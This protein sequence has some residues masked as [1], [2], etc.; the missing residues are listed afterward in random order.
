MEVAD[1]A[2]HLPFPFGDA[3]VPPPV[4]VDIGGGFGGGPHTPVTPAANGGTSN[5]AADTLPADDADVEARLRLLARAVFAVDFDDAKTKATVFIPRALIHNALLQLVPL[6]TGGAAPA[7]S[8]TGGGPLRS[9]P[10]QP[11]PPSA[12]RLA[13][14]LA[15]KRIGYWARAVFGLRSPKTARLETRRDV[16]VSFKGQPPA[17]REPDV[18]SFLATSAAGH[19]TEDG[20]RIFSLRFFRL[21][22]AADFRAPDCCLTAAE[23]AA[24]RGVLA[25]PTVAAV[26]GV[27]LRTDEPGG[28]VTGLRI[29]PALVLSP[30]PQL[31]RALS[32]PQHGLRVGGKRPRGRGVSTEGGAAGP[33]LLAGDATSPSAGDEAAVTPGAAAAAASAAMV[34]AVAA[35]AAAA[36]PGGAASEPEGLAWLGGE[37]LAGEEGGGGAAAAAVGWTRVVGV[38]L[39]MWLDVGAAEAA[40]GGGGV[41]LSVPVKEL[42]KEQSTGVRTL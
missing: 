13:A 31:G 39:G 18:R 40:P 1:P 7:P 27:G 4:T 12:S 37:C 11:P 2:G 38:D 24:L 5:G 22:L 34:A 35:A 32:Y 42:R 15:T 9:S 29:P 21:R 10:P 3:A 6:V 14:A 20:R 33:P 25:A 26:M 28:A 19:P 30:H 8:S 23:V 41:L 16:E 36:F 17:L